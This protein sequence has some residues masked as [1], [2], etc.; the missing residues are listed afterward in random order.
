MPRYGLGSGPAGVQGESGHPLQNG[1]TSFA[2]RLP[3]LDP[4]RAT[5]TPLSIG[6]HIIG[7]GE[8]HS[9]VPFQSPP[10][11]L[12][13]D[14]AGGRG[15]HRGVGGTAHIEEDLQLELVQMLNTVALGDGR[16]GI[17]IGRLQHFVGV[18]KP[19]TQLSCKQPADSGLPHTH[20]PDQ[21]NME[22]FDGQAA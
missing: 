12:V 16:A 14:D 22:V 13:V 3:L 2:Q 21:N 15:D 7:C 10:S 4:D 20:L 9:A 11:F 6:E 17:A 8:P 5:M 1:L 19:K 18:E